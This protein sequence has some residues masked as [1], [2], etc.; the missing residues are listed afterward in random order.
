MPK[1]VIVVGMARSGTSLTASIFAKNGYFVADDPDADLQDANINNPDGYWELNRLKDANAEVFQS[2]GF[3]HHNT[4]TSDEISPDQAEAIYALQQRKEHRDI[5]SQY[6][7]NQPWMWKDPRFC[8]TLG[9]WWP[10][11]DARTTRVLLVTRDPEEVFRSFSRIK[12]RDGIAKNKDDF[13]R[14]VNN[15][16]DAART[17]VKRLEISHIEVDYSDYANRPAETADA[18]GKFFGI[19]LTAND[20]GYNEKYNHSSSSGYLEFYA[21]KAVSAIPESLRRFL[22]KIAP[23]FLIRGLFPSRTE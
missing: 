17:C 8:Y 19:N 10:L 21:E 2:V 16:I 4:W 23:G 12:W 20:L 7:G 14:L 22:K 3:A 1:N 5:L 18:I 15:H 6:Q 11:V 13:I 9:Y